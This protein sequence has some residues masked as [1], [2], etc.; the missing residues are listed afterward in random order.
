MRHLSAAILLA[1]CLAAPALAGQP[2]NTPRLASADNFRDLAGIS[3]AYG[4][5]QTDPAGTASL[6]PDI[7]YR[8]NALALSPADKMSLAKLGIGEDIDL[9]TPAEIQK[10]PD[11]LP[12]GVIYKNVNIFGGATLPVLDLSTEAAADQAGVSFYRAFV[13]N[14]AERQNFRIALLDV[15]QAKKPVVFHCTAGKDRSGW[16]AVLL[17]SVAGVPQPVIV[18]DYLASNAYTAARVKATLATLP[19]A[20]RAGYEVMLTVRPEFLDASFT[21]V[22]QNYGDMQGYLTKGLGLTPAQLAELR[23]KLVD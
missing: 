7:V 19:P 15:A 22:Q 12:P 11:Q 9:R 10:Q 4:G 13:T 23:A 8:S 2:I 18:R 21:A 6:R 1:C 14:A 16:L 20:K 5:G 3:A 17:Q